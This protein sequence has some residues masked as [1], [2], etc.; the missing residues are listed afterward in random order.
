MRHKRLAQLF[1]ALTLLS[2]T[3]DS[4]FSRSSYPARTLS[5]AA[6]IEEVT[7]AGNEAIRVGDWAK[8]ESHFREAVRLAPT[9]GI[10]RIQ[11]VLV[12]GQQKKWKA[13]F[14]EMAPLLRNRATDWILTSNEKLQDGRL[15]FVNTEVFGDEEKG[16]TRYVQA[17]KG[18]QK[19]DKISYDVGVK[20][21]SFARQHKIALLYDVSKF[22]RLPF[23]SG[24]I[25]DVTNDFIT[26]YNGSEYVEQH[27]GTV[28]LYRGVD[29]VNYGTQI[30]VL[31]P[32]A[33]VYLDGKV[34]LSMPERTFIG[35]KVP[36]G[37]Y[38]FQMAWKGINRVLDV[39]ANHTYYLHISQVAYPN[40]YQAIYDV[41]EKSAKEAIRKSF[42]LKEKEIKLQRFEAIRKDPN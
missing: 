40:F 34:F 32:E 26:Y 5:Q 23:E 28:Y 37:R 39:E 7:K 3:I 13:A 38:A 33:V 15:A 17:V 6:T 20:L 31:N 24:N 29:T 8:A 22:K 10:W 9:Q 18:K 1:I 14:T 42:T 30:V 4:A 41:D 11:L 19:T 21:E 35:F 2:S 27:Y 12:L 36:V 16:I 25:T